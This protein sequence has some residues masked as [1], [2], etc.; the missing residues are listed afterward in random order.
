[1]GNYITDTDRLNKLLRDM[2]LIKTGM[3]MLISH[4]IYADDSSIMK[5]MLDL[6]SLAMGHKNIEVYL[7]SL[8]EKNDKE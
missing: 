1:M 5:K 2:D 4:I 7:S 6:D 3:V 8:R